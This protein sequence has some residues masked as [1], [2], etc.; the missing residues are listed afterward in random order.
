MLFQ[1]AE[2]GS[3]RRSSG[4]QISNDCKEEFYNNGVNCLAHCLK[5]SSKGWRP[6]AYEVI[7]SIPVMGAC[8]VF[9]NS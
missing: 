4:R 3:L 7:D 5:Y 9:P 1:S 2:L 6:F 8:K